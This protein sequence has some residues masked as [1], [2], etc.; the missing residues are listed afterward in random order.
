MWTTSP[1]HIEG[2]SFYSLKQDI[3]NTSLISKCRWV[4]GLMGAGSNSLIFSFMYDCFLVYW[5][6][7]G[8]TIHYLFMDYLLVIAYEEFLIFKKQ[9]DEMPYRSPE[10]HIMKRIFND[11][12]NKEQ[13]ERL[14]RRNP[15]LSLTWKKPFATQTNDGKQTFYGHFIINDK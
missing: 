5:K 9:I 14:I 8:A 4:G 1:I 15:F 2:F 13:M 7:Y 10:L 6:K 11:P 12:Y 3:P